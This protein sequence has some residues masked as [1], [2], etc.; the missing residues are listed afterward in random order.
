MDSA[1]STT[2]TGS[3]QETGGS[4]CCEPYVLVTSI[5]L[6]SARPEVEAFLYGPWQTTNPEDTTDILPLVWR[7][8]F[9]KLHI[10]TNPIAKPDDMIF[11]IALMEHFDGKPS[12]FRLMIKKVVIDSLD[13][14]AYE[15][16]ETRTARLIDCVN[17]EVDRANGGPNL[18]SAIDINL[19]TEDI[20]QFEKNGSRRF[21]R[22]F[23]GYGGR[24]CLCFELFKAESDLWN[25]VPQNEAFACA[26][27]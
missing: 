11:L 4:R 3:F 16:R 12:A 18:T 21:V 9:W 15:T 17:R 19:A 8:S 13:A 1:F 5:D 14:P 20:L 26:A 2:V 27:E 6:R 25:L 7:E 10:V 23:C 24:Y 22:S